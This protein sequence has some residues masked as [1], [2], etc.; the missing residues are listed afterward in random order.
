MPTP[1]I[2]P[3]GNTFI[4]ESQETISWHKY[5]GMKRTH[6]EEYFAAIFHGVIKIWLLILKLKPTFDPFIACGPE[7][8]WNSRKYNFKC[9][10]IEY[11]VW[12]LHKL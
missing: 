7:E 3:W 10:L 12:S 1:R 2:T 5:E 4:D 6:D 8:I 11:N 9:I